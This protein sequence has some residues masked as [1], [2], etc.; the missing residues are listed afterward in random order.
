[1]L[2]R[3]NRSPRCASTSNV[4]VAPGAIGAA[5]PTVAERTPGVYV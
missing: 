4:A 3:L 5:P 1:M 2:M